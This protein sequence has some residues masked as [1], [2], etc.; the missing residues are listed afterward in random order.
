MFEFATQHQFGTAVVAYWIYSAAVS[1]MP[2]PKGNPV[3]LWLYRFCHT[4]AGN[5][6]TAFGDRIPGLKALVF[7]LIAPLLFSTSACA[8]H[9][10]I[11]PGAL[12]TIDSAAYDALLVAEVTI[13]QARTEYGAGRVP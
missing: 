6:T 4:L 7:V 5:I 1:S 3:Y 13:D 8:A 2:D 11:H 12:N 10:R 9:Y